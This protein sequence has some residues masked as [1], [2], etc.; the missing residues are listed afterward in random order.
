M[1]LKFEDNQKLVFLLA[2]S[3]AI[4]FGLGWGLHLVLWK[5]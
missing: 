2:I 3:I 4:E 5:A 1:R